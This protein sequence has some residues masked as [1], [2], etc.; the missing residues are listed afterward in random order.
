MSSGNNNKDNNL[1]RRSI[2][3]EKAERIEVAGDRRI[4]SVDI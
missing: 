3:V 4:R 2:E 1:R